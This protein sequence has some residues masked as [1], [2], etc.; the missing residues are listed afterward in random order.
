[1]N[2]LTIAITLLFFTLN[3]FGQI[4]PQ[5]PLVTVTGKSTVFVEPN[6]ALISF[7]VI[8]TDN[9]IIRAKEKNTEISKNTIQYLTGQGVPKK[10]IQT[11]YLNVGLN[12]RHERNPQGED[13]FQASQTFTVC[14]TKLKNLENIISG[15]LQ[16]NIMNLGTPRFKSSDLESFKDEARK[17]AVI[18]AK[19]KAE[20]LTTELGQ[21]IG[22]VHSISELSHSNNLRIAYADAAESF[23]SGNGTGDSFALGQLEISAEITVSFIIE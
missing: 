4:D 3:L 16:Q 15:L 23:G 19:H 13:K 9:D 17:G 8:T 21:T 6:E 14:V 20:L 18:N 12:Y 2:K 5:L 7:S 10:H 11:E 1:M 22:N